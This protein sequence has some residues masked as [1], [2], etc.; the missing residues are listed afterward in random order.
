MLALEGE[1]MGEIG[2]NETVEAL[3][4]EL[5]AAMEQAQDKGV[6]FPVTG[7]QL[8]F[9]VGVKKS[10]DGKTGL[11]FW[12]LELGSGASYARETIQKVIVTLGPPVDGAG[13]P[14]RVADT[15][16]EKP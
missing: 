2:L 1:S 8:E 7:V 9:H 10:A 12:V 15:Q 3:R 14:V 5:V 6:T 4:A 16:T 13:V 11:K